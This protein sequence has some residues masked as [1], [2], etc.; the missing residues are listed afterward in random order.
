MNLVI[1]SSPKEL[2]GSLSGILAEALISKLGGP[3][4]TI[5]IYQS[6][7]KYFNFQF[8]E[9]WIELLLKAECIIIPVPMWNFT[10]PAALKDFIDKT[11]KKGRLWDIDKDGN[12]TG[13]CS[14]KEAY[15]IMT[16]G[17]HYPPGSADDFVAPYLRKI[18]SFVGI[19]DVQ[20]FRV[21][22]AS[23]KEDFLKEKQYIEQK[24]EEMFKSFHL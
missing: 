23:D 14:G 16:S 5:H 17:G 6:E 20:E 11:T 2:S 8:R 19:E 22:G 18:L 10:I 4:K 3:A 9:D 21:G 13:L 15:I 1:N 7:Q 24:T 12:F